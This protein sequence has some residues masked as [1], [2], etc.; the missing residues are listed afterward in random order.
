[1][2]FLFAP[3]LVAMPRII[4]Q[5]K[6]QEATTIDLA[7]MS[8][9]SIG[10]DRQANIRITDLKSSRLHAKL[11]LQGQ[12]WMLRD[13]DSSN[14]TWMYGERITE[15]ALDDGEIFSIGETTFTL[16]LQNASSVGWNGSVTGLEGAQTLLSDSEGSDTATLR[17]INRYLALLHQI[18]LGANKAN[19]RDELFELLDR[20]AADALEQERWAIF[21]PVEGG[22]VIWPAFEKRLKARFG[23]HPFSA[24]LLQAARA[25]VEPL[26][27]HQDGDL[28]L[29]QSMVSAGT[30]TAMAAPIV[31]CGNLQ[32]L[33]HVDRWNQ[34]SAFTRQDLEFLAAVATQIGARLEALSKVQDLQA[35]VLALRPQAA[36]TSEILGDDPAT[37]RL[38]ETI[39]KLAPVEAPV[40][41]LGE[42][43]TGKELAARA[44]HRLSRRKEKPLHTL[45][46]AAM[47]EHL[48]ES[49]LFGHVKGSF[50]G[51][52]ETRPGIFEVS[53]GATLLLDEVGEIP[54][55]LQAK[56]LRVLEQGEVQRVGDPKLRRVNVRVL[57]A[58]NRNL[59]QDVRQ[60]KFRE[61]LLH[62]LDVLTLNLPPLRERTR[63]IETLAKVFLAHSAKR[64]GTGLKRLDP[65]ARGLL[66]RHSWPGNIRELKN[67]LERAAIMSEGDTI[68]AADLGV[69]LQAAPTAAAPIVPLAE[70]ER[71]HIQK[72][73][74]HC[75][76]NKK[77]A[78]ELLGIDRSTLYAKLR[79]Y[80]M[81]VE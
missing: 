18:V 73:L 59:D 24:S 61:D 36:G 77:I 14:G 6:N 57:A 32:A 50:T 41:I 70:V 76:G 27:C 26:L 43:G 54:L 45:N 35:E 37:V 52:D 34:G 48:V 4:L 60:G 74:N 2:P 39:A 12:Q 80:A 69:R 66:L 46:C 15:T 40:L 58:T 31:A 29:S 16:C 23:A 42:S 17:R 55:Q 8:E 81:N 5:A 7:G 19:S 13:L 9:A 51:A 47:S 3:Y 28:A 71:T 44:L 78:A 1:V 20:L 33:I 67:T 21:V 75:G 68:G 10:R 72:V 65:E 53:D 56:L 64:Q 62:R 22:W 63:D 49:A 25:R 38:R 11:I 79:T 30:V